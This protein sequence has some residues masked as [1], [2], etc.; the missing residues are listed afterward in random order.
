MIPSNHIISVD[1]DDT[2]AIWKATLRSG[3]LWEP[4]SEF[5]WN[6]LLIKELVEHQNNGC[7][8][9][10]TT[11]RENSAFGN[12]ETS[13]EYNSFFLRRDYNL[14]IKK[15]NYTGGACKTDFI[16]DSGAV[17]HYDD[18]MEV[19]CRVAVLTEALPIFVGQHTKGKNCLFDELVFTGKIVVRSTTKSH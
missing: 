1:W 17:K 5:V 15:I 4:S 19:C 13:I 12:D 3:W 9:H 14:D 6:D 8:I 10:I 7:E 11:F 16:K 18:N 2:L